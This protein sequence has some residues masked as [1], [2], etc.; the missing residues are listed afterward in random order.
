MVSPRSY[1]SI[2]IIDIFL[3]KITAI[4]SSSKKQ[5]L[6]EGDLLPHQG[7]ENPVVPYYFSSMKFMYEIAVV[8]DNA[9]I[10]FCVFE[11]GERHQSL[12]S[13]TSFGFKTIFP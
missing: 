5:E 7:I 11:W 1:H 6:G 10:S 13:V 9:N 8:R 3:K 12:I 4:L 2:G